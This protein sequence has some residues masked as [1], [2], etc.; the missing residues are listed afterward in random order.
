MVPPVAPLVQQQQQ[1]SALERN[2][3]T[4]HLLRGASSCNSSSA[5]SSQALDIGDS[6]T[7]KDDDGADVMDKTDVGFNYNTWGCFVACE[8]IGALCWIC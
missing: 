3:L 5:L 7:E 8:W 2:D 1:P 6:D 4:T